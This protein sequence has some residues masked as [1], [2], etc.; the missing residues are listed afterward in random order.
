MKKIFALLAAAI[1][2]VALGLAMPAMA[3][4]ADAPKDTKSTKAEAPKDAKSDAKKEADRRRKQEAAD[5][6]LADKTAEY[7]AKANTF[8]KDVNAKEIELDRLHKQRETATRGDDRARRIALRRRRI[9][10][11]DIDRA[12]GGPRPEW[13]A[14]RGAARIDHPRAGLRQRR[15]GGRGHDEPRRCRLGRAH[16]RRLA[17]N[18][19]ARR[20]A[21]WAARV[22]RDAP[23]GAPQHEVG[24]WM[25]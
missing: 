23:N 14:A 1:A 17:V 12:L 6:E 22:L 19:T 15:R 18:S 10:R 9:R 7:R 11:R 5:K 20:P 21:A 3:Q 8:A 24:W 16:R 25:A 4:K 2:S 13:R